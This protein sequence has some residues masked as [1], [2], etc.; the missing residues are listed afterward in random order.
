M[1]GERRGPQ[2]ALSTPL[3]SQPMGTGGPAQG[4]LQ[5]RY[6]PRCCNPAIAPHARVHRG[7]AG[8]FALGHFIPHASPEVSFLQPHLN[9]AGM[10]HKDWSPNQPQ[11]LVRKMEVCWSNAPRSTAGTE[12]GVV[13]FSWWKD[14]AATGAASGKQCQGL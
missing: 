9:A 5:P 3:P 11:N 8:L 4:M 14:H 10:V 1:D 6:V 13:G 12:P 7:S 2:Y